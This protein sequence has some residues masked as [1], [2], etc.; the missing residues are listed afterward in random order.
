[1]RACPWSLGRECFTAR[2]AVRRPP[3]ATECVTI[4]AATVIRLTAQYGGSPP[5]TL[6]VVARVGRQHRR[7]FPFCQLQPECASVLAWAVEGVFTCF[8]G[9][10][11]TCCGEFL[12]GRD[13]PR[14]ERGAECVLHPFLHFF[15]RDLRQ[16]LAD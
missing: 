14:S 5:L 6:V 4:N 8:L 12:V 9:L 2:I 16:T 15:H 13:S 11:V 7:S 1:M 3:E 10:S